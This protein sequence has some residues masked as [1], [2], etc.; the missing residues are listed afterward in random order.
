MN[1]DERGPA[2]AASESPAKVTNSILGASPTTDMNE[3]RPIVD[4]SLVEDWVERIYRHAPGVFVV[5][6]QD[7]NGK[8]HGTGGGCTNAAAVVWPCPRLVD[9]GYAAF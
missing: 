6:Y 1:A 5:N 7:A 8:F 9:T 4:L 2:G 3:K